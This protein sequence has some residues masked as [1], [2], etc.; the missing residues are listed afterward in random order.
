MTYYSV[1]AITPTNQE[2]IPD[3]IEPA[4]VLVTQH[5]GRYITRTTSHQCLEAEDEDAALR[6][7]IVCPLKARIGESVSDQFLV[8]GRDDLA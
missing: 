1:L 3:Y 8:V 7:I 5:G 2:W 6:I 4:N